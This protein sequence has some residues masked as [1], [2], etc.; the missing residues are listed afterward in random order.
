MRM[1][2][3]IIFVVCSIV[4][5]LLWSIVVIEILWWWQ[6]LYHKYQEQIPKIMDDADVF[7]DL[8][9]IFFFFFRMTNDEVVGCTNLKR[10][11]PSALFSIYWHHHLQKQKASRENR[12][13]TEQEADFFAIHIEVLCV[14]MF[15]AYYVLSAINS[16][17]CVELIALHCKWKD[18]IT[19]KLHTKKQASKK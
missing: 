1:F 13:Q 18:I 5:L 19:K 9:W 17:S 14:L 16:S 12:R 7:C 15:A 4:V 6:C 10:E 8:W 2:W 3:N 11:C